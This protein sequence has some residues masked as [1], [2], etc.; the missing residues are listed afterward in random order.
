[1]V[2]KYLLN[3]SNFR[4]V[5]RCNNVSKHYPCILRKRL[6]LQEKFYRHMQ[7]Y[8]FLCDTIY[9]ILEAIN[10]R[11]S[12]SVEKFFENCL[13]WSL[14]FLHSLPVPSQ[15]PIQSLPSKVSHLRPPRQS[16]F[17]TTLLPWTHRQNPWCVF[18]PQFWAIA[19]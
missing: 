12:Y 8:A 14:F 5:T 7:K 4:D 15:S 2:E 18:F 6:I 16:N 9:R 11:C 10:G 13:G 19:R 3:S 1:M 17:Q